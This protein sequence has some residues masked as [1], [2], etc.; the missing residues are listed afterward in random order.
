[1]GLKQPASTALL[2]RQ[3]RRTYSIFTR[4]LAGTRDRNLIVASIDMDVW[5]MSLHIDESSFD[6]QPTV[7]ST[8]QRQQTSIQKLL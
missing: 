6:N 1:M 2:V 7:H 8:F 5:R 3:K 4:P